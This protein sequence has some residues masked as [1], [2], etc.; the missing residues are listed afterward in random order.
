VISP[1]ADNLTTALLSG[2]GFFV[3]SVVVRQL[4]ENV[5]HAWG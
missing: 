2:A 1:I 5:L 4:M 3:A